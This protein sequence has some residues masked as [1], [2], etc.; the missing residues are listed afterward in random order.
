MC[1][2]LFPLRK[3]QVSCAKVDGGQEVEVVS[4]SN[5]FPLSQEFQP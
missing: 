4:A 2:S 5:A 1:K 3:G